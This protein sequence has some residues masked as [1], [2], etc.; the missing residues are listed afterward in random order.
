MTTTFQVYMFFFLLCS[1]NAYN[2]TLAYPYMSFPANGDLILDL[3]PV[4]GDKQGD[5]IVLYQSGLLY[6]F[7]KDSTQLGI[8]WLD[9]T[10]EVLV[11][12]EFGCFG[13]VFHPDYAVHG[14]PNNGKFYG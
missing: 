1:V 11:N 9:L 7:N 2:L 8:P 5:M 10:S 14:S 4:P 13:I 6:R 3:R 12:D